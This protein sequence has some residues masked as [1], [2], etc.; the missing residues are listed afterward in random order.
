[1]NGV[2]NIYK[3]KGYTSHDVVA[4]IRK[5]LGR[6]KTGH[7][8]TLDPQAEGVLPVC[9]GRA[10]KLAD[11]LMATDKSYQAELILGTITDTDDHTGQVLNTSPVNY[12]EAAIQQA[13]AFFEGT[14]MQMP[15]MYSALK[16]NG[17]KLY[18]LAREGK[19]VKRKAR[20]VKIS[21]INILKIKENRI[22]MDIDC[23][24]GTYIRSLCADIGQKL[25]CGACMG[26]LVRTKSGS[27]TI[28]NAVRLDD[29]DKSFIIPVEQALPAPKAQ[30]IGD[31]KQA[32]NGNPL[33]LSQIKNVTERCWLYH[34]DT[35]IGLYALKEDVLK[36]EVM[37]YGS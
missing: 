23:S 6:V 30:L 10:T 15:P 29:L 4:I 35:L 19:T 27:F 9:I 26:D 28:E 25:G 24:K 14:Y 31:T 21:R 5:R 18:Q 7:T 12:S 17:K 13:V 22:W 1:M 11:Y 16:V 32:F 8:G 34:E 37:I 3:E 36:P 33:P 20:E 2:I